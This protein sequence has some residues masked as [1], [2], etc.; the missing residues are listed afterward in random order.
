M[1]K[2]NRAA[3]V[4]GAIWEVWRCLYDC[5]AIQEVDKGFS[6]VQIGICVEVSDCAT[7]TKWI[8]IV[9]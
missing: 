5:L 3:G 4:Q 9:N 1:I 2:K 7:L 8:S 6:S